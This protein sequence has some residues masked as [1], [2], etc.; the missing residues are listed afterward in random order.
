MRKITILDEEYVALESELAHAIDSADERVTDARSGSRQLVDSAMSTVEDKVNF[1]RDPA[2][3]NFKND[4]ALGLNGIGER[5]SSEISKAISKLSGLDSIS[6]SDAAL[7]SKAYASMFGVS[8]ESYNDEVEEALLFFGRDNVDIPDSKE[9]DF[10]VSISDAGRQE[11]VRKMG[12]INSA[13]SSATSALE[14]IFES[15]G[16]AESLQSEME[17]I[18]VAKLA[19]EPL[20][21]A[22]RA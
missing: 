3:I 4:P 21:P 6:I 17:K 14:G 7:M 15:G 2:F 22:D 9:N 8:E 20:S 10:R 5:L 1:H 18:A 11:A 13:L 19:L 16:S 12:E